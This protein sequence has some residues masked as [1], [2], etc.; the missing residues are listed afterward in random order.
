MAY[1]I[2]LLYTSVPA[3]VAVKQ[4]MFLSYARP[5]TTIITRG[6]VEDIRLEAKAKNSPSKDRS[7]QGQGPRTQAQ[8]SP[9]N[10]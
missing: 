2:Q 8:V 5:S 9:K 7:S 4:S 10:F 1:S 6:G 3:L